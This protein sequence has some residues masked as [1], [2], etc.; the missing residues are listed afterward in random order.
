MGQ[1]HERM[2]LH[3]KEIEKG[4]VW[5]DAPFVDYPKWIEIR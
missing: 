5:V 2:R 1:Y 3:Q 4:S